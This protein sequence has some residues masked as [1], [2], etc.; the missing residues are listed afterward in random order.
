MV[1]DLPGGAFRPLDWGRMA[2]RAIASK[3]HSS[4]TMYSSSIA[5]SDL[6]GYSSSVAIVAGAG[7][8]MHPVS[9]GAAR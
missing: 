8:A 9:R 5:T 7:T 1:G 6:D 3:G 4:T 2:L